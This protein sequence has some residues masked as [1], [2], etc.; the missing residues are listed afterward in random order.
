M[1]QFA[2]TIAV[3]TGCGMGRELVRQLAGEG[4]KVAACDL[5]AETRSQCEVTGLRQGQRVSTHIAIADVSD[6][7]FQR[8]D[9]ESG[10]RLG[11][12]RQRQA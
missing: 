10:L 5:P 12:P 9:A 8:F 1:K 3:V 4:C 2:K 7:F 6:D 11:I